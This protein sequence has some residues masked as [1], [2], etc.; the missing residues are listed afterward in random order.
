MLEH[1]LCPQGWFRVDLAGVNCLTS[2][3]RPVNDQSSELV[4]VLLAA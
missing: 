3:E 1:L 2:C 4:A